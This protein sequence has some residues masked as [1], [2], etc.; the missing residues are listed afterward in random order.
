[1]GYRILKSIGVGVVVALIALVACVATEIGLGFAA[2][3]RAGSGGLSSVSGGVSDLAVF[4]GAVGFAAG[5]V[6]SFVRGRAKP[7]PPS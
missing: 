5:F 7:Q 2:V 6:L 1:M 4:F 3:A